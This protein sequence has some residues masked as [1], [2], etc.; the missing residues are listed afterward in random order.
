[1]KRLSEYNNE[2]LHLVQPSLLKRECELLSS[3]GV[4]MKAYFLK[5]NKSEAVVEGFDG[6]WIFKRPSIWKSSVEVS[7]E[8]FNYPI[9]TFKSKSFSYGGIINLPRGLQLRFE[10][11]VLKD[12]Y[13]VFTD[14]NEELIVINKTGVIKKK[15]G[16]MLGKRKLEIVDEH[17]WLPMLVWYIMLQN[18]KQSIAGVYYS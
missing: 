13:T 16:V 8:G 9:A 11:K 7:K 5:W 2:V 14:T 4:L 18:L 15:T 6:K 10:S 3:E 17:P 12:V 1:M